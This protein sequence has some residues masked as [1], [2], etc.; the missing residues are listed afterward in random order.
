MGRIKNY[1]PYKFHALNAGPRTCLGVN[2]AIFEA[3]TMIVN[4]FKDFDLEFAPGWLESVPKS[5]T[6]EG[7]TSRYQAPVYKSSLSLPMSHPMMISVQNR[8]H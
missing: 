6:L 2:L 7:V 5:K 4:V 8:K 1:G 3:I